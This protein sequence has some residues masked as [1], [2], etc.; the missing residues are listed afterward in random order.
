MK[1][2]FALEL[3]NDAISLLERAANGWRRLG[4]AALDAADLGERI[5]GL[6]AL[7]SSLAPEGFAT[8]LILPNSQILYLDIE[9]PGPDRPSRR[10]QIRKALENRTPYAVDDLVF[11]WSRNGDWVKVAVL[12]K[13]TLE[14]AEE[15]AETNGF[16]P[17]A[18]VAVP[19][20]GTF[21][22][23]PY[24][25]LTSRAAAH[26]P[27][28][29]RLD[30]DQDPVWIIDDGIAEAED[31]AAD[32]PTVADPPEP[33]PE[34][35]SDADPLGDSPALPQADAPEMQD[36]DISGEAVS[37]PGIS[38]P[39][40]S[41]PGIS[42][43]GASEPKITAIA[44]TPPDTPPTTSPE[45]DEAPFI[46]IDD[47]GGEDEGDQDSAPAVEV[48][49]SDTAPEPDA[50][51]DGPPEAENA[52]EAGDEDHPP[53]PRITAFGD[54]TEDTAKTGSSTKA[55]VFQS[56]RPP[57]PA[58]KE[59]RRIAGME[60]RFGKHSD[61]RDGKAPRLG[62]AA[63]HQAAATS[64]AIGTANG[65][66]QGSAPSRPNANSP[67]QLRVT[68]PRYRRPAESTSGAAQPNQAATARHSAIGW[69]A[70]LGRTHLL[71]AAA[72]LSIAAVVLWFAFFLGAPTV[73]QTDTLAAVPTEPAEPT[74]APQP[75]SQDTLAAAVPAPTAPAPEPEPLAQAAPATN[76]EAQEDITA[77]TAEATAE[78]APE[79]IPE[80]VPEA[81]PEIAPEIAPAGASRASAKDL[82]L[83]EVATASPALVA[84]DNGAG[85][86]PEF[87]ADDAPVV[88]TGAALP[89][90]DGLAG[91]APPAP[92]PAPVPY[93]SLLR[94]DANG[95]IIATPDGVLTP[96]GFT[97]FAGKPPRLPLLRPAALT[98]QTGEALRGKK[99]R[100]RPEG[101]QPPLP[102]PED[103]AALP[104]AEATD[105]TADTGP[106]TAIADAVDAALPPPVD[107]RHAARQPRARP[108]GVVARTAARKLQAEAVADA[109]ASA[110]RAEAEAAQAALLAPSALA[111]ASSRTPAARPQSLL[112]R[113]AAAS[114]A[115]A[116][117]ID[118][119]AVD[120]ALAEAQSTVAAAAP[121]ASIA[122]QEIDEPE[123]QGGVPNI[124]TTRTVT[125]N[126]TIANAI[127]LGKINLIGIYGASSSRRALVRMPNGRYVKVK[128]GDRLDGGKV[129]AIGDNQLSYVKN[130]KTFVLKLLNKA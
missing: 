123:L 119:S 82:P 31:Q 13:V 19:E 85:N 120:A 27:R 64:A 45:L 71:A 81:A 29:E 90:T 101:L 38:E 65:A 20:A 111:V 100:A 17:V 23:E 74:Q 6:Q 78:A 125:K 54:L 79:I 117:S 110:A 47:A 113:V 98:P 103:D 50:E 3:S 126:A 87:A 118:Q 77:A 56:R 127:D 121:Q 24:F 97:L 18:F 88:A 86:T 80:A 34:P 26:L 72:V 48:A 102:L 66:G 15:F 37:E 44:D 67:T 2:R 122:D 32:Q 51:M 57:G 21:T 94:Y 63:T 91:D 41:E 49:A 4:R 36:P 84:D 42:E 11:D 76:P 39:G 75:A 28:G 5:E 116:I 30:R 115:A 99:P 112:A 60:R 61:D 14:E 129:A 128:L 109:A 25:G 89:A 95:L 53:G 68:E 8:K 130:G 9:A 43:L 107:P 58:G 106:D 22:G 62:A 124:P 40:I 12:A 52:H 105:A 10:N 7:A 35:N 104:P 16:R 108:A 96:D 73:P 55:G 59:G 1:P 93:G 33:E 114:A 83:P 92:P 46:A 70:T 69:A